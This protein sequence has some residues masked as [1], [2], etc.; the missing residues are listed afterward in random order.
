MRWG[1]CPTRSTT[2]WVAQISLSQERRNA[3]KNTAGPKYP[4]AC[5]TAKTLAEP[6]RYAVYFFAQSLT[7]GIENVFPP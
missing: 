6:Y 7:S 4:G 3:L 1:G 5:S 2:A